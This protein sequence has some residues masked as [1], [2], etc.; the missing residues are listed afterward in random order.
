MGRGKRLKTRTRER[1][2]NGKEGKLTEKSKKRVKD[3]RT[4]A[5]ANSSILTKEKIPAPGKPAPQTERSGR[6][7]K[8]TVGDRRLTARR[9]HARQGGRS[10]HVQ[11]GKCWYRSDISSQECRKI[12]QDRGRRGGGGEEDTSRR[13][14]IREERNQ[15]PS[16]GGV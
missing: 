4:R 2:K 15:G 6:R 1:I 5:R 12:T 13:G 11:T 9:F 16:K 7:Q 3:R 8:K 10:H 14:E